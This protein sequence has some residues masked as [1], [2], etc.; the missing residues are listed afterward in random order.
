LPIVV[1]QTA[2]SVAV[3]KARGNQGHGL[4]LLGKSESHLG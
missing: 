4:T 3:S 2:S 1:Q